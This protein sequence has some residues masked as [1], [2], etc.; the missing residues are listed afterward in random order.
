M[1]NDDDCDDD[2]LGGG[3]AAHTCCIRVRF[4]GPSL[5]L[6][7]AGRPWAD[8][9]P[10]ARGVPALFGSASTASASFGPNLTGGHFQTTKLA[11]MS[12]S[13]CETRAV[14]A[15]V[16]PKCL[17]RG[18]GLPAELGAQFCPSGLCSD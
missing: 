15:A 5:N 12:H 11:L 8:K 1:R 18:Q 4:W 3:I 14:L 9:R 2:R 16:F 13:D 6:R 7:L 17:W 10:S